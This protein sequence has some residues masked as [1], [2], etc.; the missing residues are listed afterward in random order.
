MYLA[1]ALAAI[2]MQQ[3]QSVCKNTNKDTQ[4]VIGKI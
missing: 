1:G 2:T 4:V 3:M